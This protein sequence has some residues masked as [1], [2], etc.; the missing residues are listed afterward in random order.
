MR[1]LFYHSYKKIPIIFIKGQEKNLSIEQEIT[2]IIY[3]ALLTSKAAAFCKY[4]R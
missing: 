1:C 4:P 2:V 3:K